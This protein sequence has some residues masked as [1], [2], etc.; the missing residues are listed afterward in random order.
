MSRIS[1]KNQVTLPAEELR[2]SGL[3]PGDDVRIRSVAPGRLEVVL[4][5]DLVA[6]FAGAFGGDVFPARYLDALRDEWR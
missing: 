4:T 1:R 3:A 6:R 2:R 5:A